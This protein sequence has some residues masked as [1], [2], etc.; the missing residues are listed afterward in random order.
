ML[1]LDSPIRQA[2]TKSD[3]TSVKPAFS[4]SL[5]PLGYSQLVRE[6]CC[7]IFV[8]TIPITHS[9]VSMILLRVSF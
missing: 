6:I 9:F 7:T 3:L 8:L 5:I 1:I 2:L 4:N